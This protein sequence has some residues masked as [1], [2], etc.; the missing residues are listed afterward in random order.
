MKIVA[1]ISMLLFYSNIKAQTPAST[2]P[3]FQFFKFDNTAFTDKNI[4]GNKKVFF[5]F[6][7]ITC[8]HCQHVIENV[9]LHY[10]EFSKTEMYLISLDSKDGINKFLNKNGSNLLN[11]RNVT[12]LL[13]LK[14]QFISKFQPRKYPSLFLYSKTKKL[15]LY[16][17]DETKFLSFLSHLK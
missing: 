1:L 2:I 3:Q 10:A 17:D 16:S 12:L 6:F 9:N 8:E 5:C 11:K 14:N 7:D 13:D 4:P 15:L